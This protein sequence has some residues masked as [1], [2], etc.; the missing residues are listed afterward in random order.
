MKVAVGGIFLLA[1]SSLRSALPIS[2]GSTTTSH[3]SEDALVYAPAP[4]YPLRA[5]IDYVE[6]TVTLKVVV[7]WET[8]AVRN[9]SIVQSSGHE[10]LDKAGMESLRQWRFKP[11][12]IETLNIPLVF[13]LKGGFN[14]QLKTARAHA[15]FSP[16]P[17]YS[18]RARHD[19]LQG[20]GTYLL[21]I[22][23][24]SG[25]VMNVNVLRSTNSGVLDEAALKAFRQWR[26]GPRT[27]RKLTI[28]LRFSFF[29]EKR[30]RNNAGY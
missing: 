19:L 2:A 26:F 20:E 30:T 16:S 3:Q 23:Y 15:V 13:E 10:V 21:T 17:V 11:H 25:R 27:L 8:G 4:E 28:P 18:F 14:G 12:T 29:D 22:D 24:D 5:R 6:G 9:V 7:D 1:L